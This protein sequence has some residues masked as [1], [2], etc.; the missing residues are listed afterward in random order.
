MHGRRRANT[1]ARTR[2]RTGF[3]TPPP[4]RNVSRCAMSRPMMLPSSSSS[5]TL[6]AIAVCSTVLAAGASA[7]DRWSVDNGFYD[8]IK[9]VVYG[10]EDNAAAA[11]PSSDVTDSPP[12]PP[13]SLPLTSQASIINY[14]N[15]TFFFFSFYMYAR[16]HFN[17]TD[18]F[19]FSFPSLSPHT[20][21][22]IFH[23]S[24][25]R[26]RARLTDEVSQSP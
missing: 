10:D 18:F 23:R 25:R 5:S 11:L 4:H 14:Y 22:Q 15:G 17:G 20:F 2:A 19:F 8:Q 3:A 24:R 16:A 6:L 12:P 21:F 7:P 26:C 13:I 9:R 1:H